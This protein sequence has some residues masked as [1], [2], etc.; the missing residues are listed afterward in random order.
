MDL[1][2]ALADAAHAG[3]TALT[4][5]GNPRRAPDRCGHHVVRPGVLVTGR[6]PSR[7]PETPS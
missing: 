3:L 4:A 1:V 5:P 6:C 2:Q 7:T